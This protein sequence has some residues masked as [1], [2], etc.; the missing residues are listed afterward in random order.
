MLCFI[1]FMTHI[2]FNNITFNVHNRI[3]FNNLYLICHFETARLETRFTYVA[4]LALTKYWKCNSYTYSGEV[5]S[6]TTCSKFSAL[7]RLK[8][9]VLPSPT[10]LT[11]A[12]LE[13]WSPKNGMVRIGFPQCAVS[14]I[15]SMPPWETKARTFGWPGIEHKP[16]HL[17][18]P[19]TYIF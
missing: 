17:G 1:N 19:I 13:Y 18:I 15:L 16:S 7:S 11:A 14:E 10:A 4:L 6:F 3:R 8:K 2:T 12:A 9:S 5:N